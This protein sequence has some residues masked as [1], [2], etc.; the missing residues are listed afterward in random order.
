M[1]IRREKSR[2]GRPLSAC[3]G[4]GVF[5]GY[6]SLFGERDGTGDVMLPGAFA[7]SIARKGP[8]NV[9][10]LFQHNPAEPVGTWLDIH[11]TARGLHVMGRL[12]CNVQRGR[13]L[14]SLLESG[15]LDGLSIGFKTISASRDKA[16]GTRRLHRVDLW[17]ISLVTF[18]MLPGAC[19]SAMTP[20]RSAA[21]GLFTAA[22]APAPREEP[23]ALPSLASLF[24]RGARQF[25]QGAN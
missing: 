20:A 14:V 6:A 9:R 1:Q 11:E 15:G 2:L 21:D 3:S 24:R 13:E 19:V 22:A 12:D 7:G 8:A 17:E 4:T 16:A 23:D 10:M 25:Q 5:V 18:P